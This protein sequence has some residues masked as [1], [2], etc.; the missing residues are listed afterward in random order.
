ME[1][2]G[3]G[4]AR[5]VGVGV[6]HYDGNY[7]ALDHAILDVREF[8]RV[9]DGDFS[10]SVLA[11]PGEDD[12]RALLRTLRGS[13]PEGG[14]LV[15]LWSGHGMASSADGLRLLTR[16]SQ[17]YASDGLGAINDVAAPCAESGANQILLIIDTCFSG[18]A[19][20]AGV[21][22]ARI[23]QSA[24]PAGGHAWVG[25]L[26]SCLPAE[27]ARDG[28][29]GPRLAALLTDGPM[30]AE[31]RVRWSPHS[32]FIRGD[33]LCDALLKDWN[34][35]AQS[36]DFLSRG[37]AWWMFPNPLYAGAGGRAHA[38][39]CPWGRAGG[40]K[41]VVYRAGCR[42]GSSRSLG[43]VRG[44]WP[45]RDHG[46]SRDRQDSDRRAGGKPVQPG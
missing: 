31:L 37:S 39:S 1:G 32:A 18:E 12:A 22:A 24:P 30:T 15:L 29:F 21:V 7:A 6:G 5:F 46:L 14:S 13:M 9:I 11:D 8:A 17:G 20:T 4:V 16:D 23:L 43:A 36:P 26:T 35:P 27:T 44:A 45:A 3:S 41:V 2:M 33:D 28:V 25:V 34:S 38:A 40:R 19:I 42:S 10:C